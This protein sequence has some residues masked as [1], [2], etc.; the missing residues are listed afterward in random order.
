MALRRQQR[1]V[2][3]LR[4]PQPPPPAATPATS[5]QV[6]DCEPVTP[7]D[8]NLYLRVVFEQC[9]L[10]GGTQMTLLPWALIGLG[11]YTVGVPAAL[12]LLLARNRELVIE[13]QVRGG[14]E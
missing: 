9:G 11:V 8:G 14:N 13:D 3:L 1:R 4:A 10:P 2:P 5:L 7:P 12:G 6:L